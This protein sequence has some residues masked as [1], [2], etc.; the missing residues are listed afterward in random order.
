M[1]SSKNQESDDVIKKSGI[2]K[3]SKRE[4]PWKSGKSKVMT[5][6]K[7]K[8]N[9]PGIPKVSKGYSPFGESHPKNQLWLGSKNV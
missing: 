3:V 7:V 6:S 1:T 9:F 8:G 2:P 4:F 5:S